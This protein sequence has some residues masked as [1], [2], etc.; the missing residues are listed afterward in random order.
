MYRGDRV[1]IGTWDNLNAAR[2]RDGRCRWFQWIGGRGC[3]ACGRPASEHDGDLRT[4]GRGPFSDDLE[5]WPWAGSTYPDTGVDQEE[6][7]AHITGGAA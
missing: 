2:A 1:P 4:G 3:D 6:W 5:G 7:V